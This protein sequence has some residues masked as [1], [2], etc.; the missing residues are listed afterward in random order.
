MKMNKIIPSL[1][2]QQFEQSFPHH[3]ILRVN[4]N[5]N[6]GDNDLGYFFGLNDVTVRSSVLSTRPY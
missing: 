3:T 1:F 6:S 2:K 5:E 4:S